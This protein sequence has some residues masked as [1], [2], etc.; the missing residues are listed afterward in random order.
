MLLRLLCQRNKVVV[1]LF[2]VTVTIWRIVK[3]LIY[4]SRSIILLRN[5]FIFV[6]HFH[7]PTKRSMIELL[8]TNGSPQLQ[9]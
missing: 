2:F 8:I 3:I 5:R 4:N 6:H 1:R 9:I 7:I